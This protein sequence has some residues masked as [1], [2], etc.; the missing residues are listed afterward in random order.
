VWSLKKYLNIFEWSILLTVCNVKHVEKRNRKE[1]N[2]TI[3]F[4]KTLAILFGVLYNVA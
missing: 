2:H 1:K 4:E 3:N